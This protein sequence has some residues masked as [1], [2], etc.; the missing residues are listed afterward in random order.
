MKYTY[1]KKKLFHEKKFIRYERLLLYDSIILINIVFPR[2][3]DN[4]RIVILNKK[5]VFVN[6]IIKKVN[7]FYGS[8]HCRS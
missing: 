2:N 8:I 1:L 6:I 7:F 3:T 5:L 4:P